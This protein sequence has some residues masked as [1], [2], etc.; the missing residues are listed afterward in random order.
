VAAAGIVDLIPAPTA[1]VPWRYQQCWSARGP[2][3]NFALNTAHW[4]HSCMRPLFQ[5]PDPWSE[6]N[7]CVATP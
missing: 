1:L 3:D 4:R 5:R 7:R 6:A 2:A